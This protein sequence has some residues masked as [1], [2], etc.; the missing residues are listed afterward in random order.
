MSA[1]TF[2]HCARG[3]GPPSRS[4]PAVTAETTRAVTRMEMPNQRKSRRCSLARLR[5]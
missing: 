3:D 1:C 2:S 5:Q 4:T